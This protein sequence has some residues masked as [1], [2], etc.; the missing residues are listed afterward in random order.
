MK[1]TH[2]ID[3]LIRQRIADLPPGPARGWAELERRMDRHEP[4]DAAV[5][6]KLGALAPTA[7]AG[8]WA[9]LES[10]LAAAE[11]GQLAAVDQAVATGLQ[12][13]P[14]TPPSGWAQLA[15]RLELIG[16]RREMVACLKISEAALLLSLLLLMFR[17]GAEEAPRELIAEPATEMDAPADRPA[18]SGSAVSEQ[19]EPAANAGRPAPKVKSTTTPTPK[20]VEVLS[21]APGYTVAPQ[22]PALPKLTL[23]ASGVEGIPTVDYDVTDT[24]R[25]L[26]V[27][28]PSPILG[29]DD[30]VQYYLNVFVSPVDFNQVVTLENPSL[31]IQAQNKLS[32]GYSAGV[33]VDMNQGH[34]IFQFGLTYGYRSYVPAEIL[35]IQQ[36]ASFTPPDE[37]I[38]YGRLTYWSVSL[39][40]NYQ[41][42]LAANDHWRFAAGA[43]VAMNL[44]LNSKFQLADGYTKED[45]KRNI[46]N[47]ISANGSSHD[48][49]AI[50]TR[51]NILDPEGGYLQGGSIFDNTSLYLSGNLRV[52]RLLSDRWSLYFSPTVTRLITL[53]ST[54]GGK[55]P[56]EDRIHNTMLRFGTRIRLTGK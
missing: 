33:L 31:G 52:E 24:H 5:A 10:K 14:P 38:R 54:D 4:A 43:G 16:Q 32:T 13:A 46:N 7:A 37:D 19:K 25:R 55:G 17:F 2:P 48:G 9:V 53:R 22:S 56:L 12:Q 42:E 11:A 35:N 44:I 50:S 28:G 45:L 23:G 29:T 3:D 40:L 41:R 47:F 34:N 21:R 15:A 18:A 27:P 51:R 1:E 49:R 36:D 6:D 8:S 20:A 26:F 30:P 39:P